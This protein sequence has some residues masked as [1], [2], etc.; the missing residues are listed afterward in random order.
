MKDLAQGGIEFGLDCIDCGLPAPR[1]R[2]PPR[3]LGGQ[4]LG[5]PGEKE[6]VGQ[7]QL[8]G[9]NGSGFAAADPVLDRRAFEGFVELTAG[10][11]GGF[12]DHGFHGT[13]APL[14]TVRG[15]EATSAL[16]ADRAGPA[17]VPNPSYS[18]SYSY[19]T[20]QASPTGTGN[21]A[22]G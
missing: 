10:F 7:P 12:F 14:L 4:E 3:D 9:N 18:Y 6:A 22:Q 1:G 17:C 8:L 20:R 21:P 15:I 11:D 5:T 16:Q 2:S 13:L 19:S